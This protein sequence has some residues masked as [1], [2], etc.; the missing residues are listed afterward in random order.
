MTFIA[1][2]FI[3]ISLDGFIARRDGDIEW[4]TSRGE[5]AGEY[6]YDAFI[7]DIDT[8]VMGRATYETGLTFDAWPHEG[9]RVEV[10]SRT[11]ETD[12]PRVTVHR[13]LDALIDHLDATARHV[14]VDGGQV[15]RSFLRAGRV[16]DLT[17]STVPVLIG[18]GLPLFGEL[19]RDVD[20]EHLGTEVFGAGLVQSRYAVR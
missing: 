1:S 7:A 12:D 18:S 15:I 3:G 4:L 16:D 6:G 17:I 11:L 2:V 8:I 5:K 10:L 19:E 9:K 14:Y 13:D 20:L